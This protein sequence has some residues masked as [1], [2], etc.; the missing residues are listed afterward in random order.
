[1]SDAIILLDT[2]RPP[3]SL[4][5]ERRLYEGWI[6]AHFKNISA[7]S[8]GCVNLEADVDDDGITFNTLRVKAP[9]QQD[10]SIAHRF[11]I[12]NLNAWD[13]NV[14]KRLCFRIDGGTRQCGWL[15]ESNE[16]IHVPP[17]VAATEKVRNKVLVKSLLEQNFN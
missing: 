5:L 17:N 8:S 11:N 6:N 4:I 12:M 10:G 1:L 9:E 13:L 2:V 7:D 3:S 15:N 14:R 16:V